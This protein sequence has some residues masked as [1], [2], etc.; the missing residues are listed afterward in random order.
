MRKGENNAFEMV[1]QLEL[2]RETRGKINLIESH[3][4][5]QALDIKISHS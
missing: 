2:E 4:E 1:F 3:L 5:C